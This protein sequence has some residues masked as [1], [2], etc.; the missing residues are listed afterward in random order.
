MENTS[1]KDRHRVES[2]GDTRRVQGTRGHIIIRRH[3]QIESTG[4]TAR[5]EDADKQKSQGAQT[6][7]RTQVE[8][9]GGTDRYRYEDTDK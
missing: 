6:G 3:R 7:T 9:T 4:D 1:N 8:S 2:T 5:Y